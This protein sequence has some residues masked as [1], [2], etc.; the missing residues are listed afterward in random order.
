MNAIYY[1][2]LTMYILQITCIAF[3]SIWLIKILRYYLVFCAQQ[4]K[5]YLLDFNLRMMGLIIVLGG[6]LALYYFKVQYDYS[7]VSAMWI[8]VVIYYL[9]VKSTTSEWIKK[10]TE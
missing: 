8:P 5:P 1:L 4:K 7:M 2:Y 3:Y 9:L 6:I 10:M